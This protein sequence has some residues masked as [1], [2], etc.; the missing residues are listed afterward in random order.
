MKPETPNEVKIYKLEWD[1][2]R[3]EQKNLYKHVYTSSWL[4]LHSLSIHTS[5]SSSYLTAFWLL[6]SLEIQQDFVGAREEWGPSL[7]TM[8]NGEL[9][10]SSSSSLVYDFLS[11]EDPLRFRCAWPPPT[12]PITLATEVVEGGEYTIADALHGKFV[13]N[14]S[15][16]SLESCIFKKTKPRN[17]FFF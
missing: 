5:R 15:P 3:K 17:F 10:S 1:P 8:A 6:I 16:T 13:A 12:S 11:T 14:S 7:R 4:V 9:S 2:K